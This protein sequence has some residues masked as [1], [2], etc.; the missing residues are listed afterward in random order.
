MSFY[1]NIFQIVTTKSVYT[2]FFTALLQHPLLSSQ[3]ETVEPDALWKI[4]SFG[5]HKHCWKAPQL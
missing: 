4:S 5:H 3:T 1:N 2:N